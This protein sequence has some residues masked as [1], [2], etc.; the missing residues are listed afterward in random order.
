MKGRTQIEDVKRRYYVAIFGVG[1]YVVLDVIAQL[2]PPHYSPV[3]QPESDLAVGK[4]GYIMT[5]NFLIRGLLSLEFLLALSGT[6]RLVSGGL[7]PYKSGMYLLGA[8]AVGAFVLAAFPTDVPP[9][10]VSW[11][12]AIHLLAAVIAFLGGGIGAVVVSIRM[13]KSAE[14]EGVRRIALPLGALAFALCMVELFASGFSPRLA[15]DY[16]GLVERLFLGSVLLWMAVVSALM[17]RRKPWET[18]TSEAQVA[19]AQAKL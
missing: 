11:H 6:A 1:L 10:P 18:T 2:L 12:G 19:G 9:T 5:V 13:G 15:A 16:G 14:L 8:W 4:Y 17:L 7:S 3:T